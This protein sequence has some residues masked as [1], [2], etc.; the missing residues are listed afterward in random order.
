MRR[1]RRCLGRAPG[2]AA[3]VATETIEVLRIAF[4]ANDG[5]ADP[6]ASE[7]AGLVDLA[8]RIDFDQIDI[9]TKCAAA[10]LSYRRPRAEWWREYQ[11][12]PLVQRRRRVVL[13]REL[14]RHVAGLDAILFWG[15][16]FHP[17]GNSGRAQIP[18][19]NYVDQ[20]WSLTPPPG[21][22]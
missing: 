6:L 19:F 10:A 4:A 21:E 3:G 7:L 11:M 12:H 17:F 2:D 14:T 16:W 1:R 5:R 15:S 13:E 9:L 18:F 8:V 20:S 22:G